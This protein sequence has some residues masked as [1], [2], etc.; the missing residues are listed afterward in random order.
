MNEPISDIAIEKSTGQ[1]WQVWFERLEGM[2]ARDLSHKEIATKLVSDYQVASWWAQML[3]VRYEQVTGRRQAGQGNNGEYAVSISKTLV[4][5][6]NDGMHWWLKRVQSRTEFNDV[7]IVTSSTTE[8]EKW[9]H[10]RVALRDGSRAVVSIY[11]K[12]PTKASLGVQHEKLASAEAAE[13]WR[14]YWK[15][16]LADD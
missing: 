11:E 13:Q 7:A 15:S 4:G 8:T 2:G 5:S 14:V 12:T 10:Y 6:M 3:T 9:R 16:F 1:P